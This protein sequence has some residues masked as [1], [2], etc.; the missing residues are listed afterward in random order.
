MAAI[1]STATTGP[2]EQLRPRWVN[3]RVRV[4]GRNELPSALALR[5][6][7]RMT[8]PGPVWQLDVP[9]W[10]AVA[11][12]PKNLARPIVTAWWL[13]KADVA[14]TAALDFDPTRVPFDVPLAD[15]RG[16]VRVED[17]AQRTTTS[18]TNPASRPSCTLAW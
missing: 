2:L 13:A 11:A 5:W 3:L 16:V 14:P 4:A 1:E 12:D 17:F 18:R 7:E 10:R 15:G 9:S 6:R 8:Y